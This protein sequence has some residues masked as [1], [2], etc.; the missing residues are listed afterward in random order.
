L[1]ASEPEVLGKRLARPWVEVA[2]RDPE[3]AHA[4]SSLVVSVLE[5]RRGGRDGGRSCFS[6][7]F[8]GSIWLRFEAEVQ[9]RGNAISIGPGRFVEIADGVPVPAET[10]DC[11]EQLLAG[12]SSVELEDRRLPDGY[13]GPIEY[14]VGYLFRD[15]AAATDAG[16]G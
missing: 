9:V 3:G 12:E 16:P 6:P 2:R 15:G 8:V 5:R 11:I 1:P 14:R 10:T 4:M 7:S 13:T